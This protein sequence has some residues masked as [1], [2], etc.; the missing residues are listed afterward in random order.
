MSFVDLN[1]LPSFYADGPAVTVFCPHCGQDRLF[2][3]VSRTPKIG[4]V[5]MRS[6]SSDRRSWQHLAA[7]TRFCSMCG[8]CDDVPPLKTGSGSGKRQRIFELDHQECVYCGRTGQLTLDHIVPRSKGGPS[9]QSN[10]VTAC[11]SC[12]RH[13]AN[14]LPPSLKYGRFRL[15]SMVYNEPD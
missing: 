1:S 15:A 7:R 2:K 14:G 9:D 4:R 11:L 10:L 8:W 13:K 12:N 5:R 3:T 6:H